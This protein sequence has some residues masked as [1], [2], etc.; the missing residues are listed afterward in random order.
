M[1]A[2]LSGWLPHRK[3]NPQKIKWTGTLLGPAAWRP[4][5][6]R[7]LNAFNFEKGGG[8]IGG[9][10][11]KP[12]GHQLDGGGVPGVG[13]ALCVDLSSG[14]LEI[15]HHRSNT[16]HLRTE[17]WFPSNAQLVVE[18]IYREEG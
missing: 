17:Q 13:L 8:L 6:E 15:A 3:R 5:N 16:I 2:K 9:G 7:L 11:D 10:T 4:Y 18:L 12:N 14:Q 1:T